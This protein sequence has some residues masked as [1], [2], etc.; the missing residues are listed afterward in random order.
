MF[1]RILI[2]CVGN[3]CRSPTAELLF[4][5]YLPNLHVASA[6]IR[7]LT[8]Q[9]MDDTARSLVEE[10]GLD[11]SHHIARQLDEGMIRDAD[12]ILAMERAHVDII[13]RRTPHAMGRTLLLN[14]WADRS[15]IPDPYRQQRPAFEHVYRMINTAALG[16]VPYLRAAG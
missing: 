7:A 13:V 6:G 11:G 8:G 14:K 5:H 1:Q 4:R 2:V 12:L 9:G 10:H 3:I 16:W 15:D